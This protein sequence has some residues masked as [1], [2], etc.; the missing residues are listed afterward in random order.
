M[1][2]EQGVWLRAWQALLARMDERK[3][4]DW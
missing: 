1:W 4:L 3:F 2:E